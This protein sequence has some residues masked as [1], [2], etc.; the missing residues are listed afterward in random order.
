MFGK[1]R[2]EHLKDAKRLFV[3]AWDRPLDIEP[4]TRPSKNVVLRDSK[5]HN[6]LVEILQ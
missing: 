4:R 3:D 5:T 1:K 2:D 6:G